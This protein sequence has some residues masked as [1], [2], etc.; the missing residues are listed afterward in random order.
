MFK[1]LVQATTLLLVAFLSACSSTPTEPTMDFNYYIRATNDI[2]PDFTNRPSPVLV[3]VYQ[4]TNR[5]NFDN[6]SYDALFDPEQNVLG[7]EFIDMNEYLVHPDTNNEVALKISERSK[8]IG[9]A[10][11]YRAIDGVNWRSVI[12]VPDES[13]WR[14]SAI[15]IKV[16]K[17]SVSVIEL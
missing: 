13:F 5:V 16:E 2:N 14:D 12:S 9:V 1:K 11:G 15:E 7:A 6:A 3:R 17:V 10:V 8:F 4:L